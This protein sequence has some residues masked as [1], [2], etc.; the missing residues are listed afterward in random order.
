MHA[1]NTTSALVLALLYTLFPTTNNDSTN[2]NVNVTMSL[3]L[4]QIAVSA[5]NTNGY[6]EISLNGLQM[7]LGDKLQITFE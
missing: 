6:T 4:I 2:A 5:A 3:L 1:P 7:R